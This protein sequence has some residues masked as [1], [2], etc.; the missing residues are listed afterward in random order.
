MM[1][2]CISFNWFSLFWDFKKTE[3]SCVDHYWLLITNCTQIVADNNHCM[4]IWK[5]K[6]KLSVSHNKSSHLVSSPSKC[7]CDNFVKN[8]IFKNLII[9]I[10]IIICNKFTHSRTLPEVILPARQGLCLLSSS[11]H[12]G[13]ASPTSQHVVK[14]QLPMSAKMKPRERGKKKDGS[15]FQTSKYIKVTP[16]NIASKRRNGNCSFLQQSWTMEGV[17]WPN[18]VEPR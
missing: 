8:N 7:T 14:W 9:Y 5:K 2:M 3:G 6:S 13:W 11:C 1:L 15:K 4:L 10:I 12:L 17:Y 18:R 16:V